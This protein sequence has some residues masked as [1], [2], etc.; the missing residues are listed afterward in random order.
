MKTVHSKP[1]THQTSIKKV[2]F[3]SEGAQLVGHLYYPPNFTP[4]QTLPAI[5][6]SGSWTT[7]KEQMAGSY[8]QQLA[9]QGF[10]TLAFDFRNFGE[11]EGAPRFYESPALKQVDIQNAVAYLASLPEVDPTKIGAL[12]VC[13]GAM[14]TLMAAAENDKIRAVVTVA[15]WLHDAEA[16][17]LFYGGEEGVKAKIKAAQTAKQM[18]ADNGT[19]R[20]IPTISTEDETAAMYGAYD[21]YLNPQ[22]GAVSQWSADKFAVM[23]WEDWLTTDPMPTAAHL[24]VPTLMIHSD[25]AVLPQYTK[26]YFTKIATTDKKLHWMD[27]E[28]ESP[29]HQFSYYDQADEMKEAV[30]EASQWF[31]QKLK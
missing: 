7:V 25:G 18:Y 13:A 8:A 21:Y 27:T 29:F 5:V 30:T 31:A 1:T 11:S 4:D 15:S 6:V 28:L 23:S 20:Y 2:R 14:Y 26:N 19:V 10:I 12:G 16:V 17:K 24:K 3:Q 22:R 9:A